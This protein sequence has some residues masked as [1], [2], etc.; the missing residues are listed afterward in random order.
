MMKIFIDAGHNY[1]GFDT[2]AVG[3]GLREQ[4][5]TFYVSKLLGERLSDAGFDIKYSRENFT[6][7]VGSDVSSSI[8]QRCN[9]ANS[10]GADYFVSIHCNSYSSPDANGTETLVYSKNGKSSI[11]AEIINKNLAALGLKNRGV[12]VRSDLGVLKNTSMP[13]VIVEL[14]FIS[15]VD[16]AYF[17][18]H[19][20]SELAQAVYVAVLEFCGLN[21]VGEHWAKKY[22][23]WLKLQGLDILEERFDDSATRGEL[24]KL[25]ALI[26][27]YNTD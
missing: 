24:F 7:N 13:A 9:M 26:K 5:I 18:E 19:R 25:L 1:S 2:G 4:D 11:L 14:A 10:W 22:Y 16:D 15:N 20:Q 6:D 3:H 27:G 12:K 21:F 8:A 23:D 17:L